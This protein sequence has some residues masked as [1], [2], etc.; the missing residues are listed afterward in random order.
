MRGALV[1]DLVCRDRARLRRAFDLL[2]EAESLSLCVA[3]EKVTKDKGHPGAS[4]FG[5]VRAGRAFRQGSCPG[6]KDSAS[7]PSPL[8]ALSPSPHRRT[9]APDVKSRVKINGNVKGGSVRLLERRSVT[10]K[11]MCGGFYA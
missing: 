1:L 10:E 4:P 11:F 9:G 7:V 6:E 2:P 8:R 5:C 3:K